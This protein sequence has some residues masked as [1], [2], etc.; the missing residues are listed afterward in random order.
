[1]ILI[2][3]LTYAVHPELVTLTLTC[4]L[5][6]IGNALNVLASA[7][8]LAEVVQVAPAS[9][10]YSNTVDAFTLVK[11]TVI[12]ALLPIHTLVTVADKIASGPGLISIATEGVEVTVPHGLLVARTSTLRVTADAEVLVKVKLKVVVVVVAVKAVQVEPLSIE[13]S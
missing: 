5:A 3:L 9:V 4:T 11:L 1:M 10:L 12:L 6:A 13:Y 7:A 8:W 2:W